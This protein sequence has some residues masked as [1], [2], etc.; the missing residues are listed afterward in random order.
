MRGA[1]A[2]TPSPQP[3]GHDSRLRAGGGAT[4]RRIGGSGRLASEVS[5]SGLSGQNSCLLITLTAAS[6]LRRALGQNALQGAA[7]HI[8]PA[9]RLGD[10]AAAKFIDALNVLPADS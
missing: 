6:S 3:Q 9:R 8:E 5:C 10:I 7:M 4:P 1:G 2:P